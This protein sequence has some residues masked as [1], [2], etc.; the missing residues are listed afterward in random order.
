MG[1]LHN[2]IQVEATPEN[3]TVEAIAQKIYPVAKEKKT[4]LIHKTYYRG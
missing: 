3:T 1:I 4:E 2:P